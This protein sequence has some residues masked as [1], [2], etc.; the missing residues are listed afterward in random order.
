M[1]LV[2]RALRAAPGLSRRR[3]WAVARKELREYR[4]N[5]SVLVA[6]GIFPLVFLIQPVIAV[7]LAPEAASG[8]IRYGNEL[9]YLLGIPILVPASLAAHAITGERQQGSLEPV[10]T[11]PIT[12]EEFILGKAL[13]VLL[14]SLAIAYIVY[15]VFLALVAVG[16]QP[17]VAAAIFQGQDLVVQLIYTPLLAA[18]TTWIGLVISTRTSDTRVAQQ[19]SILGSLPLLIGAVALAFDV[20]HVTPALLVAIGVILFVADLQGWRIVAP[21]F[22]RERLITGTRN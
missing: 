12:R 9:L 16:A 10:L 20:I 18:A 17:A 21:M 22:D 11:T 5:R 1:M 8:Q 2:V 13:A 14:P 19:L 6:V 15:G 4:R 7:F 3:I